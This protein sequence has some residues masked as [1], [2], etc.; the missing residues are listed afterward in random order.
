MIDLT[1]KNAIVTGGSRGIGAAVCRM[2]AKAGANVVVGYRH[3]EEAANAVVA[4]IK[5]IGRKG[6]AVSGDL[7]DR[8][9]CAALFDRAAVVLGTIDIVVGN[10]GIWKK[11]YIDEMTTDEWR[12]M[13]SVNLDSIYHTCHYAARHMNP[14]KTGKLILIAS[15]AGQR[16]EAYHAHYAATKG[17]VIAMTKS[18]ANELGYYNINVN[19][20]SP[21]WVLTDMTERVFH[22]ANFRATVEQSI[23]L[24]RIAQPEDVAGAVLFLASELARHIQGELISVNG[25]SLLG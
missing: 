19:C 17:G 10:A 4:D 14:R 25:G 8:A 22:D 20:V 3:D 9:D 6:L 15:T 13:L 1:G 21:G 16:G 18:L 12:E 11:A 24:R 7:A 23:P 2:L 5:A